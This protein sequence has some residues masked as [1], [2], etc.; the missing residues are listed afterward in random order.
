VV[1]DRQVRILMELLGKGKSLITAASK[2]DMDEKTAR[3]YRELGK[4]PS[5]IKVDHPAVSEFMS[6]KL[7]I[8]TLH[9]ICVGMG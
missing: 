7:A 2:A 5:D 3:K 9:G 1:T 8:I 6:Q 4:L